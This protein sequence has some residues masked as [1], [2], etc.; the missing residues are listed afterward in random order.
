MSTTPPQHIVVMT[1]AT[2]GI[3][4]AGLGDRDTSR[5]PGICLLGEREPEVS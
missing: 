4:T 1:G 5:K 2:S 3:G